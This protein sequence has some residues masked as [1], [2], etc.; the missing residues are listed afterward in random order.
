M[1]SVDRAVDRHPDHRQPAAPRRCHRAPARQEDAAGPGQL[2]A[3]APG[4]RAGRGAAA[5][6]EPERQGDR[7]Q[8][9][10]AARLRRAGDGRSSPCACPTCEALPVAG[11]AVAVRGGEA[12]HRTGGRGQARLPGRR[13]RTRP[14]IAG[15]CERVDGLPL[16]IEL[17]AARVKLFNPQALL[18]RLETSAER[19]RHGLARPA[20]PPAD[21]QGR[22]RME[23]RPARRAARSGCSAGSR[24]SPAAPTS[25]RRRRCAARR[26]SWASTS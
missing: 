10:R 4:G 15:I 14:P 22:D 8:P 5:P 21:A 24:C 23:L 9:R 7:Q 18:A 20:G 17:A 1:A 11:G 6:G 25:S 13:T 16:A 12:L 2:R 26:P 19:A 3:A